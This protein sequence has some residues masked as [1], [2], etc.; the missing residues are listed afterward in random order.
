MEKYR[1][2]TS[3]RI[4]QSILYN[5]KHSYLA[6]NDDSNAETL[7]RLV[8]YFTGKANLTTYADDYE[9]YWWMH[10]GR[11]HRV[12]LDQNRYNTLAHIDKYEK[13]GLN[14]SNREDIVKWLTSTFN[15]YLILC[16]DM[17]DRNYHGS[18]DMYFVGY[19]ILGKLPKKIVD[20]MDAIWEE[21]EK[22]DLKYVK[23]CVRESRK[24][25]NNAELESKK[26]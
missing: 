10:G 12:P 11:T 1:K 9:W 14:K 7:C 22:T 23:K 15:K 3:R 19:Y 8:A 16:E 24:Q 25:Q 2:E 6:H 20:K 4:A 21:C 5:D 17:R 18:A 26:L 13:L